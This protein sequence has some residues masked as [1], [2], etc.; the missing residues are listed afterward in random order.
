MKLGEKPLAE[1]TEDEVREAIETLRAE[2]QALLEDAR[3][4]ARDR[5]PVPKAA[6]PKEPKE[7]KELTASQKMLQ[8]LLGGGS[9]VEMGQK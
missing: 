9:N 3:A 6:K 7:P 5:Q 1:M 4:R 2:R 8:S